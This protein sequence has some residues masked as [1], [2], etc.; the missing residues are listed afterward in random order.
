MK[1][2][3]TCERTFDGAMRFCQTDGTPLVEMIE[4]APEDPFKTMIGRQEDFASEVPPDPFK[5]MVGGSFKKDDSDSLLQLTEE[6]DALK[7]KFISDEE[8]K[9]EMSSE[10]PK[11]EEVI[12]VSPLNDVSSSS[13]DKS[14]SSYSSP[15]PKYNEPSLSPPS[16]GDTSSTPQSYDSSVT[17]DS[18]GNVSSPFSDSYSPPV[19]SPFEQNKTANE[20]SSPYDDSPFGQ[21]D[22]PI[23]SPFNDIN[24]TI[25]QPP[26]ASS[27]SYKEPE[28]TSSEQNSPFS[29]SPFDQYSTPVNQPLQQ[30][31]WSP[32]APDAGWQNQEIGA[33][34]Q[35]QPAGA[36]SGQNQTL[37]IVSLVLGILSIP[38][39]TG[40]I[41]GIGAAVTGFLAKKKAD[42]NPALYGGKGLALTGMIIGIITTLIGLITNLLALI[43]LIPIP[44]F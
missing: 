15:T 27:P 14:D 12:G 42:E 19:S 29:Q 2:C 44:G 17:D 41:F 4:T 32:P 24:Q 5:T 37:A 30:S 9:R 23:P 11:K 43:G 13:E 34:A 3:P 36:E 7:T 6:P 25:Y 10:E 35:F 28:T 33:N 38:C 31:E 39:C 20:P 40:V 22:A 1:K 16:F 21:P 26:A 18:A 8:M